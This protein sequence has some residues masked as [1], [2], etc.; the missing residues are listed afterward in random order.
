MH[1]L[2]RKFVKNTIAASKDV[3][4][5]FAPVFL[6]IYFGIADNHRGVAA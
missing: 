6:E 4:K 2:G 3:I 5:F 1:L